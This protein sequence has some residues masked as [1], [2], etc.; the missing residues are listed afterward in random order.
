MT[1]AQSIGKWLARCELALVY[2]AIF[3]TAAM[4]V[5]TTGDA[6]SR[7]FL[8]R[9]ILGAYEITEKY[10]MVAAIFLGLSYA[11]RGGAFIRVTF[12]VDRLSP[13]LKLA[14]DHFAH[15]VSLVY[16]IVF[17]LATGQQALTAI[18]DDTTLT[19]LPIL[20]GPAYW[21]IPLGFLAMTVLMLIDLPRVREGRA[22]LFQQDAPT[23]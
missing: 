10:L 14:A 17:V 13:S 12:L 18:S 5:L 20:V 2:L 23:S 22:M 4:M 21:L 16:C 8:N 1:P 3:A 7:Y 15:L 11:Y 9:P 19:T 6:A